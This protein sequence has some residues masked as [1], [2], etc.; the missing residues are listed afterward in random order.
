[1]NIEVEKQG[2]LYIM[3]IKTKR[4][5]TFK[6]TD[7]KTEFLRLI[8][9]GAKH[10]LVNLKDVESADSSGL[11]SLLFGKRQ[12]EAKS[13]FFKLSSLQPKVV[14]LLKIAKLTEHFEFYDDEESAI[15][16]FL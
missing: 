11:G 12:F 8:G 9:E 10:I 7:I 4:L 16:G 2:D 14:T 6:A 13:G 5:D 3:R 15:K 1:M